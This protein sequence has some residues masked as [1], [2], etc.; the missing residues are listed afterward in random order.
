MSQKQKL[1]LNMLNYFKAYK[2]CIH[3][4]NRILEMD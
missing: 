1:T 3:I 2:R 4:L